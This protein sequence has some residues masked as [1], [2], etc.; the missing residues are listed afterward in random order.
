MCIEIF[1]TELA[2][3]KVLAT[4]QQ[5]TTYKHVNISAE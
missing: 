3:I 1:L 2:C 4:K 5:L